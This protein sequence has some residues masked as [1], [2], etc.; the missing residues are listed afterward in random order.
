MHLVAIRYSSRCKL[1]P[2]EKP[3][4]CAPVDHL[5]NAFGHLCRVAC[6]TI[7]PIH[8]SVQR[9]LDTMVQDRSDRLTHF[10]TV[11][12]APAGAGMPAGKRATAGL[13]V[14]V[15]HTEPGIALGNIQTDSVRHRCVLDVT[16][17]LF[18]DDAADILHTPQPLGKFRPCCP[19]TCQFSVLNALQ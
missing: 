2:C 10:L 18:C 13:R 11:P 17:V 5:R 4:R 14:P 6:A 15:A 12:A 3:L 8:P 9:N 1:L 16:L 7:R 19:S